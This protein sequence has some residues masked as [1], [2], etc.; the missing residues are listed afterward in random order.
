MLLLQVPAMRSVGADAVLL[1]VDADVVLLEAE[2]GML[3]VVG[4]Y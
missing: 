3:V 4:M 1:E 2:V